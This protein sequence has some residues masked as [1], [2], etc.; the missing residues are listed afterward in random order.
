MKLTTESGDKVKRIPAGAY[1]IHVT[2]ATTEH[3]FHLTGP[4][5]DKA[6]SVGGKSPTW[7]V[8]FVAGGYTYLCDPHAD[9]MRDSFTVT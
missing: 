6:T 4:G 3:N 1:R 2:D 8:T 9:F 5:V 7:D